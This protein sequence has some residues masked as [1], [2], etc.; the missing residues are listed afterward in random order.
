MPPELEFVA[1][2]GIDWAD[3]KHVWCLRKAGSTQRECGEV[4]HK[5]ETVEAWV[6]E[7]CRRSH[8]GGRGASE[9]R[10]GVHAAQVRVPAPV[11]CAFHHVGRDAQGA[12]SLP[13]QG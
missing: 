6:G 9:G 1:L 7:L 11:P 13:G 10:V 3:Q 2:V 4:E 12:L 8:R 5:P